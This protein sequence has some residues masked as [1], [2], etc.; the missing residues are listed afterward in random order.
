MNSYQHHHSKHTILKQ[1]NQMFSLLKN[2][3]YLTVVWLLI[4]CQAVFGNKDD[5]PPT[6]DTL[7][8]SRIHPS[9]NYSERIRFVVLHYTAENNQR[10]LQLLTQGQVSSHYLIMQG[11]HPIYQLVDEQKTAWHA[12]ASSFAGRS[13]LNDISIGIEIVNE[14]IIST[15]RSHQ[16]Y[17]AYHHFADYT[18]RQIEQVGRLLQELQQRYQLDPRHIVAH[19]DIA[20]SR[21]IDTGAKFPWQH[22]YNHYGVGAW[23]DDATYEAFLD[24]TDFDTTSIRQI[25]EALR[26]YGYTINESDEWDKASSDVVYAFQ[27]HFNPHHATGVMD[28]QSYAILQALNDKYSKPKLES[29]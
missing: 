4:G 29:F 6:N 16:G 17:P 23:Y 7:V 26:L 15:Y 21:K 28:K 8:I 9:V 19:A 20:P 10:S 25:K 2:S 22:L 18:P 11:N 27:L 5:T 12:G 13:Q 1:P 14:G 3:L 24:S